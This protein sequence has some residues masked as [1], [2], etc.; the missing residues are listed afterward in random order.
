MLL[1]VKTLTGQ[2]ITLDVEPSTTIEDVKRGV[3]GRTGI[4]P[5]QQRLVFMGKVVEDRCT[6][7]DYKI[8]DAA[9]FHLVLRLRGQ[10]DLVSNHVVATTPARDT[11]V[12][13]GTIPIIV[14]FDD[15]VAVRC[16]DGDNTGAVNAADV[17][18]LCQAAHGGARTV[19]AGA[20][21]FDRTARTL[22]FTPAEAIPAGCFVFVRINTVAGRADGPEFPDHVLDFVFATEHLERTVTLRP[23][24]SSKLPPRQVSFSTRTGTPLRALQSAVAEAYG[25]CGWPATF[26]SLPLNSMLL[27]TC[28]NILTGVPVEEIVLQVVLGSRFVTLLRDEDVQQLR[29]GDMITTALVEEYLPMLVQLLRHHPAAAAEPDEFLCPITVRDRVEQQT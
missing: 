13:A 3:E 9:T 11:I 22:T 17:V 21:V 4:P 27:T 5:D 15:F 29:D 20:A 8:Q 12:P 26:V 25:E 28:P 24:S 18:V 10:G 14:Q 16:D 1:F 6:L 19:V 23:H 2:T 7:F